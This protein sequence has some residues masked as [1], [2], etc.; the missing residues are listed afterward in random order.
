MMT[1]K[2]L[3][4]RAL[5][6][7]TTERIPWV[8]FVGCHAASLIGVNAE[9]YF[10]S[11]DHIVSGV[12]KAI[13]LY[14]PDGIPSLFDLQLE[15]ET[16]GCRLQWAPENPPS[17]ASHPLESDM[18]LSELKIPTK[19]D[20]RFPIVL[21][22]TKRICDMHGEN[23]AIYGLITGP[24]TL[25]LHLRGTNIFY[26]MVDDPDYL[27]ELMEFAKN[28]A[29]ATA[30]MYMD[31]GCDIIAL[32]DPMTSQ[33]SPSSFREFVS[34]YVTAVFDRSVLSPVPPDIKP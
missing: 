22:A 8:P 26:D 4:L 14:R 25:A 9:E 13:E 23:V 3:L 11:S 31:T 6:N 7:E 1:G 16:M 10:K 18:K 29:I 20:G 21:D 34:P 33:I 2:Q 17:V 15:A 28:V 19:E 12:S 24:F 27:K 5:K 30:D 32:V